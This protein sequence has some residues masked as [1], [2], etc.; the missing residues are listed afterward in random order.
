MPV[1]EPIPFRDAIFKL[2]DVEWPLDDCK[3]S[4][5]GDL[6]EVSTNQSEGWDELFDAWR[7]MVIS[8]GS[9]HFADGQPLEW[10]VLYDFVGTL[11]TGIEIVV[12]V[13]ISKIEDAGKIKD[14]FR[15]TFEAKSTGPGTAYL[16]SNG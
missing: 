14:V 4:W 2:D 3:A 11:A 15:V 7:R 12:P 8:G 13:R 6:V 10:G 9:P 5:D 1:R 16:P